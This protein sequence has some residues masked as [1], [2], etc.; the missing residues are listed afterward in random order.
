MPKVQKQTRYKL[1]HPTPRWLCTSL[2]TKRRNKMHNR[3]NEKD[4][5]SITIS[6]IFKEKKEEKLH[7]HERYAQNPTSIKSD[8]PIVL[9]SNKFI[10]GL[11]FYLIWNL[12]I[13][14][15]RICATFRGH[16][17]LYWFT[18]KDLS[19][20]QYLKMFRTI[21]QNYHHISSSF[22]YY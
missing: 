15:V 14:I 1:N 9:L 20:N 3:Y 11:L 2:T 4:Q 8:L 5:S 6:T 17:W 19:C 18:P 13:R 22:F 16:P 7:V 12:T 10:Y 21:N